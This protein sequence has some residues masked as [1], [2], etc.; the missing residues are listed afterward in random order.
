[1]VLQLTWDGR[2]GMEPYVDQQTD[3]P[4]GQNV[5]IITS[6]DYRHV[7]CICVVN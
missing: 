3:F 5:K 1:M 7:Q 6:D 2:A 4:F